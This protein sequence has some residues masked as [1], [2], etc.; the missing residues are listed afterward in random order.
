MPLHV[1]ELLFPGADFGARF[2]YE[3]Q[4]EAEDIAQALGLAE[5]FADQEMWWLFLVIIFSMTV[6]GR[7]R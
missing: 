5:G 7:G 3:I 4:D 6:S 2:T 1:F